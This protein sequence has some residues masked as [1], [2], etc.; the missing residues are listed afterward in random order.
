MVSKIPVGERSPEDVTSDTKQQYSRRS[1]DDESDDDDDEDD[2]ETSEEEE[3]AESSRLMRPPKNPTPRCC[4]TRRARHEKLSS[5]LLLVGRL[6]VPSAPVSR[7]RARWRSN[8]SRSPPSLGRLCCRGSR[9][10]CLWP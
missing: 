4:M 6:G 10:Q 5:R 3:D 1:D 2:D 9:W 7:L 8:P